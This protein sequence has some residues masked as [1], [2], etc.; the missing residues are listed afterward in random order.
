[1]LRALYAEHLARDLEITPESVLHHSERCQVRPA[2]TYAEYVRKELPRDAIAA[3]SATMGDGAAAAAAAGE[4]RGPSREDLL[5]Y[6]NAFSRF[7]Y[8]RE[9]HLTCPRGD[10]PGRTEPEVL[11][12][13]LDAIDAALAI[14]RDAALPPRE[15][16]ARI[17]AHLRRQARCPALYPFL[18]QFFGIEEGPNITTLLAILPRGFLEAARWLLAYALA[19]APARE[20]AVDHEL[21]TAVGGNA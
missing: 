8:D 7:Y 2:L 1:V 14:R 17:Q 19:A 5:A 18:R 9:F 15:T 10:L 6:A 3:A 4:R 13:A 20:A 21:L 12:R 16:R 11:L